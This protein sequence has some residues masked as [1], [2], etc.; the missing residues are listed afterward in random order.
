MIFRF[1][2]TL[3]F[4]AWSGTIALAGDLDG[5]V[6][7]G[8]M[9]TLFSADDPLAGV[10]RR[11]PELADLGVDVIWLSPINPSDDE[12]AI[13]YSVTDYRGLREDFG[14]AQDFRELVAAAHKLGMEVVMDFV[15]NHCSRKHPWFVD[16]QKKGAKSPYYH[17]FVRDKSGE[18]AHYFDWENMVN[19]NYDNP[20]LVR[21]MTDAMAY[22]MR[23]Y[24]VDGFRMDAAWGIKERSP[25]AWPAVIA[26]LEKINPRVILIAEAPA[27]ETY[28][29]QSHFDAAYDWTAELGHWAWEDVFKGKQ[30]KTALLRQ[31]LAV[32]S[33]AGVLRFLNNND[34]GARFAASHEIEV[35][36]VA[37]V[38]Q[39]T[40]PG[41][42]LVYS[43]DEVG[44]GFDPYEDPP[45]L[46][47]KD[48]DNLR[49]LYKRLI[50]LWKSSPAL[51]SDALALLPV[52]G[53]ENA[54]AYLRGAGPHDDF[55]L[56]ILNFGDQA[57]LTLTLPGSLP[58]TTVF[59]DALRG[60][61]IE[62]RLQGDKL[63]LSV[64]A[65]SALILKP[66]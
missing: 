10:T 7:Y 20:E 66:R 50:A 25:A 30:V 24:G 51:R 54:C 39:F 64:Q 11:L 13:S 6:V 65:E 29:L 49:P 46:D 8:V 33:P 3:L 18:P 57:D 14:T 47:W 59:R 12:S 32:P 34:T 55:A 62:Q 56:V 28:Y 2:C 41:L 53:G 45:P 58:A 4:L 9:P 22:W 52:D 23:E 44:A 48:P 42:P 61:N 15:P 37:A 38:L 40:V 21:E 27:R 19:L 26:E 1:L 31:S 36:G 17:Y 16:A 5:K 35:T 43:G 60:K 63:T